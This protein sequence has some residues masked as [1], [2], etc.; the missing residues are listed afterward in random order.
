MNDST[1]RIGIAVD[2]YKTDRYIAELNKLGFSSVLRDGV[3]R[4]TK[5]ITIDV[6]EH[7]FAQHQETIR[8][9]CKRLEHTK[10]ST[11]N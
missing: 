4:K 2:D 5:L 6:P 10:G 8:R 9:M 7:M 3:T 11:S 1:R